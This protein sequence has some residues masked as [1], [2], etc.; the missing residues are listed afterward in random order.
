MPRPRRPAC[1]AGLVKEPAWLSLPR[2]LI[3]GLRY[4]EAAL[5][6]STG[7]K[8]E[9]GLDLSVRMFRRRIVSTS[10]LLVLYPSHLTDKG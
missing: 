9:E 2:Q 10:G 7:C 8:G 4:L 6:Q 5:E 1:P 3:C